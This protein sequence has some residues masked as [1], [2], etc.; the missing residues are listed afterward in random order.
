MK[1]HLLTKGL[2][3]LFLLLAVNVQAAKPDKDLYEGIT[4]SNIDK[5]RKAIADGA[6]VNKKYSLKWPLMWALETSHR[7]DIVA[8]L[9][10]AGA[11]VNASDIKG[12][13]LRQYGG[14]VETPENKAKWL[15]D[16]YAKYKVDTTITADQFSSITA[17]TH[18][19]LDAG[20]RPD[21]GLNSQIGSPLQAC[22]AY[23]IGSEEARAEFIKALASHP[24]HPANLNDRMITA[25]SASQNSQGFSLSDKERHPTPLMYAIQKGQSIVAAALIDAGADLTLTMNVYNSE[26]TLWAEYR[27]KNSL[28]ALDIARAKSNKAIEQKLLAAGNQ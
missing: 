18:Q 22:V 24:K 27:T 2:A 20:A 26:S 21:E 12:S 11:D 28:T 6:D 1:K 9:I 4:K 17:I 8:V 19:L 13:L 10:E 3:L 5:V 23:G 25:E 15:N 7:T 14:I 16:F